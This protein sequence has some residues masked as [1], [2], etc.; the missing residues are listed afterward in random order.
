MNPK[1]TIGL[2]VLLAVLAGVYF[3]GGLPEAG[4]PGVSGTPTPVPPELISYSTSEISRLVV[5][6]GSETV[7]V[8]KDG[9]GSWTYAKGT[10]TSQPAD[11]TRINGLT[12][13]LG[14][15]KARGKVADTIQNP[16]DY[17]LAQPDADVTVA[18]DSDRITLLIGSQ[19]PQRTGYYTQLSGAPALYLVESLLVD[20]LKRLVSQPPDPPTPTAAPASSTPAA[21]G[22]PVP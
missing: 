22:T 12:M 5:R 18:R 16:A 19:N 14:N 13:R 11:G 4:P 2:A 17:G 8:Q 15:L 7:T 1:I 6:S 21:T 9:S 20:D 3:F 10:L